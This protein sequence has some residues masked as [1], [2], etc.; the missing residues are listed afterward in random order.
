MCRFIFRYFNFFKTKTMCVDKLRNY[1][2]FYQKLFYIINIKCHNLSSKF[3]NFF[4]NFSVPRHRQSL[5]WRLINMAT[6]SYFWLTY[7]RPPIFKYKLPGFLFHFLMKQC[8]IKMG[9]TAHQRNS[10][11]LCNP[12]ILQIKLVKL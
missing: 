7:I 1:S 6:G 3:C 11:R 9:N 12:S 10:V 2:R 8:K 5:L 4:S